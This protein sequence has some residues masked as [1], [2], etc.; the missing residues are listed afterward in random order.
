MC[1]R[2]MEENSKQHDIYMR[3]ETVEGEEVDVM[4][5]RDTKHTE[6]HTPTERGTSY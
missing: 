2:V 6:R 1:V 4:N 3:G 5:E